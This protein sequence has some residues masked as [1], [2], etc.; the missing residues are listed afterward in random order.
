MN[1]LRITSGE[2]R[3]RKIKTPSTANTHPMGERE[4]LALFN[5]LNAQSKNGTFPQSARVLDLYAGSGALG[6]EALSRGAESVV[7]VELDRRAADCIAENISAFSYEDRATLLKTSAERAVRELKERSFDLIFADP[8]Y[9]QFSHDT[10]SPHGRSSRN[11]DRHFDP[12]NLDKIAEL[13]DKDGIFVLSHPDTPPDFKGL[14]L[15]SSKEY[16]RAHLSFYQRIAK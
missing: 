2:N 10:D 4:R 11:T 6:F 7:F 14:E 15:T 5:R 16:A 9:E 8:P 3:N 13:L 1:F 12:T